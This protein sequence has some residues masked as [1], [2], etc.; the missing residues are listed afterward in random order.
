[1]NCPLH[2]NCMK[3]YSPVNILFKYLFNK[4]N[5]ME[6]KRRAHGI[7]VNLNLMHASVESR[8]E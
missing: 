1:M 6:F 8:F 7:D 4:M 2:L 3:M 5:N